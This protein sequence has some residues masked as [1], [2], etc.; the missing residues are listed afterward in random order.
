MPPPLFFSSAIFLLLLVG[1]L[2]LLLGGV[3]QLADLLPALP[4]DVFV[5][6]ATADLAHGLAAA[7]TDL[8]VEVG[9]VALLGRLPTALA[10]LFACFFH[11][12]SAFGHAFSVAE[13]S[14]SLL[15][16][17]RARRVL[18][19]RRRHVASGRLVHAAKRRR[20]VDLDDL[21]PVAADEEVDARVVEPDDAR[22]GDGDARGA[23]VERDRVHR[24][25]LLQ[26]AA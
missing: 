26:V 8:A 7:A 14:A 11:A 3:D 16:T 9:A 21:S 25:A 5:E 2:R 20:A 18:D 19:D 23:L 24:R 6:L 22:R 15:Q 17:Q 13:L 12:H 4:S 1:L 10:A